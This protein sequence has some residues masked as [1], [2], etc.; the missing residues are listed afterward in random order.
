MNPEQS[1]KP[2]HLSDRDWAI[3]LLARDGWANA[4][5]G[6]TSAPIGYFWR[7]SNARE[8]LAELHAALED[9]VAQLDAGALEGHFLIRQF[10]NQS[11][12]V[13]QC[14]TEQYLVNRFELLLADYVE[15]RDM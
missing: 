15:W 9:E 12:T 8:E 13:E 3:F 7:M 1:P 11:V 2:E 5:G 14:I 6:S 10:S 4:S